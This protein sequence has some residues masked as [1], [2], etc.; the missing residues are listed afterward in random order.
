MVANKKKKKKWKKI[1]QLTESQHNPQ[2]W[3]ILQGFINHIWMWDSLGYSQNTNLKEQMIVCQEEFSAANQACYCM[4]KNLFSASWHRPPAGLRCAAVNTRP[5]VKVYFSSPQKSNWIR[6]KK[7]KCDVNWC[8]TSRRSVLFTHSP[9]LW[10]PKRWTFFV[11]EK[12]FR[13]SFSKYLCNMHS[14]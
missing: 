1:P 8:K 5:C 3:K 14:P 2:R 4:D 6:L 11:F 10:C 13:Y 7:G 12:H 9:T